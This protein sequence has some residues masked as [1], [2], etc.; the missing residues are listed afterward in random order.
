MKLCPVCRLFLEERDWQGHTVL[1]CTSCGGSWMRSADFNEVLAHDG[2]RLSEL[3]SLIHGAA[4]S[5]VLEGLSQLCPDC[6][7]V[8]LV[9]FEDAPEAVR[10]TRCPKC[11]GAWLTA[12]AE[13][14]E[15]KP[16][17]PP[18]P[19][20]PSVSSVPPVPPPREEAPPTPVEIE[21]GLPPET[22][23]VPEVP[24]TPHELLEPP[25]RDAADAWS[26]LVDGNARFASGQAWRPRATQARADEVLA[27]QKP[28]AAVVCCSDSRV[29]PEILLDQGIGD[30]FVVR[31]AGHVVS[32]STM[33]SILYAA[34]HLG[35]ELVVVLGHTDCGAI[36]GTLAQANR[37]HP[38]LEPLT[39]AIQPAAA[40]ADRM[41]GDHVTNAARIHASRTAEHIQR[42]IA[43][44]MDAP[45][46]V[47]VVAA[48]YHLDT[49]LIERVSDDAPGRPGSPREGEAPAEPPPSSVPSPPKVIAEPEPSQDADLQP[50]GEASQSR[51]PRWCPKCRAGYD[52]HTQMC[53]RCGVLLVQPWYRVPCLKCKKENL[54]GLD[55][56]WNCRAD[57]H[58]AWLA[59]GQ[60]PPRPPRVA[61][62]I[63]SRQSADATTGC[64]Q[65]VLGAVTLVLLVAAAL[66]AW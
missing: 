30:I 15:S 25:V 64:A 59:A 19:P 34:D 26:R 43:E 12:R 49:R 63:P 2:S 38:Y 45:D 54:I 3:A 40:I 16:L 31:T 9:P 33:A 37:L 35:V 50:P 51:Y 42:A 46:R 17:A 44:L 18:A 29:P 8:A 5:A 6:Q 28:F 56:C 36:K 52:V 65:S 39:R 53:P 20:L 66:L 13:P 24:E 4:S 55:R 22:P 11:G 32:T 41:A 1:A 48:V 58:P 27:G 60:K 10:I 57:L 14:T 7:T 21:V 61:V 23:L 62:R 47:T